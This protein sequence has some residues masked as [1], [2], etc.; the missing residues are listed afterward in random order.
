LHFDFTDTYYTTDIAM[1]SRQ[2]LPQ[3][4]V[5]SL[6]D[7]FINSMYRSMTPVCH[8]GG[9]TLPLGG[10]RR[11]S[12]GIQNACPGAFF[13]PGMWYYTPSRKKRRRHL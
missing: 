4:K 3:G 2:F 12:K 10:H 1:E 8:P 7:V 9:D 6:E 5:F 11:S 13:L